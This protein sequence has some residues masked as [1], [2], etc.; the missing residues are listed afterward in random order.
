[1]TTESAKTRVFM[2]PGQGSQK[3][4][5]GEA[6]FAKFPEQTAAASAELGYSIEELCLKDPANQLDQTQFTQP[7]LFVI[8][9]LSFLARLMENAELPHFVAGHSLGEYDALFAAGVFD[10]ATGVKLVKQRA[11]LMSRARGGAMAAVI[12]LTPEQIKDAL[13]AAGLTSIDIANL[14]SP[15][16]IVISGPESDLPASQG[17]LEKAGAQL[18]K[19]LNVSAA[20]HSRYMVAAGSE[21]ATFLAPFEFAPPR[22]PVIS[23]VTA[24]PY[25]PGQAKENLARQITHSVR[26]TE[27][28]QWL[29]EKPGAEFHEIGPGNVLTG[30]LRRIQGGRKP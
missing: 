26:W 5:M 27:S 25:E 21:F 16:Q 8:N 7:A 6:L 1:M 14:N 11:A 30:L 18:F 20:F 3:K 10:F 17:V 13:G 15:N 9:A 19:R 22:I 4:G 2:F 24:R 12:G 28:I 23:N 29:L